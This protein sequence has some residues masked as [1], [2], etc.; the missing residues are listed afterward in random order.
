MHSFACY[1]Y[2]H[3]LPNSTKVCQYKGAPI[4]NV[5]VVI[6]P[7]DW[8]TC[9][10]FYNHLIDSISD[11]K[12]N[13]S[14]SKTD[15]WRAPTTIKTPPLSE[16][17]PSTS[18]LGFFKAPPLPLWNNAP[19]DLPAPVTSQDFLRFPFPSPDLCNI[20]FTSSA[21]NAVTRFLLAQIGAAALSS[22]ADT[23]TTTSAP[24]STGI[25]NVGRNLFSIAD[26]ISDDVKDG[27]EEVKDNSFK[28]NDGAS[29]E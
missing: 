10:S 1:A 18:P 7:P 28:G 9:F 22:L 25:H 3:D 21:T 29:R 17:Q 4:S 2:A 26:H 6:P 27:E 15:V 11:F 12:M 24:T 5:C 8:P 14:G 16:S 19:L 20:G 13:V 23:P